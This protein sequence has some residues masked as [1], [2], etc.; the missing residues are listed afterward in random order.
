[1]DESDS[2]D[3]E[4]TESDIAEELEEMDNE[5]PMIQSKNAK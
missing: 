2:K 5:D 1:V 4:V 3:E